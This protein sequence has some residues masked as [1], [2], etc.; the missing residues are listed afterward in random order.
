MSAMVYLGLGANLGDREENLRAALRQLREKFD[1]ER[2][3]SLYETEP[4]GYQDQPRFLN[5]V[6]KGSTRLA[7]RSLLSLI[8]NIERELGRRPAFRNA[9]RPV[10]VD[11][12]FYDDLVLDTPELT[13]PH[14]RLAE[15]AFV[16]VPLA[17]IAPDLRHP[18]TGRTVAEM[19]QAVGQEGVAVFGGTL[20]PP[21]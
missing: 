13:L 17:E 14:P 1:L 11:I 16:L 21:E 20:G 2:V 8:K 10:D 19:L 15:R 18:V 9:P 3:S 5:A 4:V 12:L 6:A 7:P